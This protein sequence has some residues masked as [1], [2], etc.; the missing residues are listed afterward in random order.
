[1]ATDNL[2]PAFVQVGNETNGGI[3]KRGT[4]QNW[5]RDAKLFK[6]GIQAVRDFSATTGQPIK[7]LLHVAQ[8]ENTMWWFTKAEAAGITD[9]DVI[10]VS[11]YP[12][13]STFSIGDMGA[14]VTTLRQR[15]DKEVMILET[16]YGWSR[17]SAPNDSADNVLNQGLRGYSFSPE[18]QYRFM[19]DLTQ[20]LISNGALGVVYWEPAW[21]STS[22][23]TRWGQGSHW[24]NATFF[25]FNRENEVIEGINFLNNSYLYPLRLVDGLIED[26]YGAAFIS[27]DLGDVLN[28]I[29]ALDLTDFYAYADHE[30]L[31]LALT[32]AG[33]V[34]AREGSYLLYIDT[35]HDGQGA[36]TDVGRRP[37][38][39]ANP[40]KPEFR[41]DISI[42]ENRG[43]YLF[44]AWINGEWQTITFTGG[45]AIVSGASSVIEVQLPL[46]LINQ[47]ETLYIA[48]VSSDRGRARGASDVLGTATIPS[49]EGLVIEQFFRFDF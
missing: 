25:D 12:Q 13:W 36:D 29:P 4:A 17:D 2:I 34:F 7:I 31:S 37:I 38:T 8:P 22:C 45:A 42:Q 43:N 28:N 19:A 48:L 18:G 6:A 23:R 11:Y 10:G 16:A 5:S 40:F 46:T 30:K 27:D 24:E 32:V 44:N 3:L 14:Q 9:F 49:D 21:V 47:P 39:I 33:D 15:F 41:L 35:T 20:S 1:L 26:N